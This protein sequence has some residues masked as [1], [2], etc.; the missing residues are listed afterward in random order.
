MGLATMVG[1]YIVG[2]ISGAH[3]N[4]A[5]SI[6]LSIFHGFPAYKVPIYIFAQVLGAFLA[7]LITVGLFQGTIVAYGG[8]NLDDSGTLSSFIT[9]P[10]FDHIDGVTAF[11]A[12]FTA[13]AILAISVLALGDVSS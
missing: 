5:I 2:G 12:G 10:R 11:F 13:A 4:P 9:H 6:M 8:R 1:I 7:T 3:L